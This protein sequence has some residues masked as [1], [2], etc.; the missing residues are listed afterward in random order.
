MVL[1]VPMPVVTGAGVW[2]IPASQLIF[3]DD[4]TVVFSKDGWHHV[5]LYGG[6]A[7]IDAQLFLKGRMIYEIKHLVSGQGVI[8]NIDGRVVLRRNIK[9]SKKVHYTYYFDDNE[10]FTGA[11][12]FMFD[13]HN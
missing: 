4:G 8:Q 2:D 3:T 5:R 1:P 9:P 12:V 11:V 13:V 10:T 6:G 7:I